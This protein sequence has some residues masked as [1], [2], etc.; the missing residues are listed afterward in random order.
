MHMK[1]IFPL[2]LVLAIVSIMGS[3]CL[4]Q[5]KKH[6]WQPIKQKR[7]SVVHEVQWPKETLEIVSKWYTGARKNW[8]PLADANP[9]INP[10]SLSPGTKI[11]IPSDLVKTRKPMP[12]KF[13]V[14]CYL[15]PKVKKRA[16]KIS[17][18]PKKVAPKEKKPEP[19]PK[20]IEDFE[21]IG[22]K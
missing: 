19:T 12:K 17:K 8:E 13:V 9:S 6:E 15:K 18:A 2:I 4:L 11:F 1:K 14:K 21:V 7:V 20:D 22:P 10:E 5:G 3:G 16:A